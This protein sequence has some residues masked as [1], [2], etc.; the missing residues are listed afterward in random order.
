MPENQLPIAINA[1]DV[2]PATTA[3]NYPAT[4]IAL[5]GKK[6][7]GRS[8]RRLGDQFGLKNFGVNL[9]TLAPKAVS[10][11]RHAHAKQDEFIYVL[12]GQPTLLTDAGPTTLSP[13][14]CAGFRAGTGNAHTLVNETVEDVIYLEI[15]DRTSGDEVTYP[16]EDL[17]ASF[18][19]GRWIFSRKD[20]T[21]Y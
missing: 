18:V 8:K 9:T 4:I 10:S 15:G 1:T 7:A 5:L 3:S 14:M 21:L 11:I 2:L 17:H 19:G 13:G 20:G 6:L 12:Q 16:D